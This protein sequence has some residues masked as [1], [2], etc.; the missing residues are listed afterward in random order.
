MAQN[1]IGKSTQFKLLSKRIIDEGVEVISYK[2]PL[3]KF[4]PTGPLLN[5]ILRDP[6]VSKEYSEFEAQKVFAQN[7]LEFQPTVESILKSGINV[8]SEDYVGTGISW[9]LT[10]DVSLEDL[11]EINSGLLNPDLALLLDGD[12]FLDKIE[13]N[14][15]NEDAQAGEWEK[16]R[17]AHLMLAKRY[18]WKSVNANQSIEKVHSDIWELVSDFLG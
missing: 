15:R 3:Y 8:L 13:K 14:H 2:Y 11:E 1:N 16:S 10:R 4:R 17:K 7:R 9:G 5:K 6:K 12:R 18:G